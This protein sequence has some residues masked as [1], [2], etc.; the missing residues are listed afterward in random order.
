MG[1]D[2]HLHL[3]GP[4][5]AY[6]GGGRFGNRRYCLYIINAFLL[7]LC[8]IPLLYLLL[9]FFLLDFLFKPL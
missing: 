6:S 1:K 8:V 5:G 4:K 3:S 7:L 2:G 9:V